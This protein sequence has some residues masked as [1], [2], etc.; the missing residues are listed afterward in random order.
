MT[1]AEMM[2][3]VS[4]EPRFVNLSLTFVVSEELVSEL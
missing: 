1:E 3:P 2:P 4:F